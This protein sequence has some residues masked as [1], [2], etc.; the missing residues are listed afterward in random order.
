M[1]KK[2]TAEQTKKTIDDHGFFLYEDGLSFWGLNLYRNGNIGINITEE[3]HKSPIDK[4]LEH[5]KDVLVKK[6]E[7]E[8][9]A[10]EKEAKKNE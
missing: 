3:I 8:R 7:Q 10:M 1:A 2:G 6:A 9:E 4:K 5:Y